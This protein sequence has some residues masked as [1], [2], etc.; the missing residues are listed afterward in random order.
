MTSISVVD[1]RSTPDL[2]ADLAD[3]TYAAVHGWPDQRPVTAALVRSW[4]RPDEPDRHHARAA[5]R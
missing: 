2:D 5:P 3:L 4:L 1:Y